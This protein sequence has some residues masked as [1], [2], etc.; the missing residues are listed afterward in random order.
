MTA[1][2]LVLAVAVGAAG[3]LLGPTSVGAATTLEEVG[4]YEQPV[5]VTS[6]PDDPDRLFV[7]ERA[8]RI[9]LTAP[10]GTSGFVDLT[11]L[12]VS[13]GGEQ[14]LLSVAFPSDHGETGL[15]YIFYTAAPEGD[16]VVAELASSGS[17]ADPA[18]LREVLRVP[19]RDRANHNGGQLQ[20][21]P[22]GYLYISTGD[23]GGPGDP[24]GNGQDP[25]TLLG[26]LLRIDPRQSGADPYTVPADNPFVGTA[27]ADE[28]WS[29]GLRNPWRFSFDREDGA[30]TIGDVGQGDREEINYRPQD[31]GG[32]RGDNFGWNCR[33]GFIA[34]PGAPEEC[35]EGGPF[36]DPVF[37]YPI[38]N[39]PECAI[40]GGYVVRDPS[41]TDLYGR[42]LYSDFCVGELRSIL[43][44]TPLAGD[45]R[46]EDLT[47]PN[48]SSF[49]EDACGRFYVASL[50]DGKVNR[51]VG[52]TEPDCEDPP[53]TDPPSDDP[54]PEDPPPTDPPSDDPPPEDPPPTTEPPEVHVPAN[55]FRFVR[56]D[57]VR[58][59][60]RAWLV[61]R[62]RAAG[63]LRLLG[64]KRVRRAGP[65]TVGQPRRVRLLVRP[66]GRARRKLN[67]V[68][69]STGRA[70]ARVRTRVRFV[71]A[72]GEPRVKSRRVLL[73]KRR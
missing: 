12:V 15:L 33:E 31:V 5:Y 2:R 53:P 42:Y 26:A 32:G 68:S 61:V 64:N 50:S 21:G 70:R 46:S 23:G 43:L 44:N 1:W 73:I 39:Q 7:V 20:F 10:A 56:V 17:T 49:G 35:A 65:K 8:G 45:D 14:G 54:P 34:Y 41:L 55:N 19:H 47:V 28:I 67:R 36:T 18:S 38:R 59:K 29:W 16:L 52:D 60:G 3:L 37:D 72:G 11:A 9:Q 4:G 27:N 48:P 66:K 30:L 69:R 63:T 58:R 24:G 25:T 22:D 57:R 40:T 71:P 6:D 13:S 62:V 51:L